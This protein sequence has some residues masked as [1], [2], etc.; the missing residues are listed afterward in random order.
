MR[1][2]VVAYYG[3]AGR[4]DDGLQCVPLV[5]LFQCQ[6]MAEDV[7]L[8]FLGCAHGNTTLR[9]LETNQFGSTQSESLNVVVVGSIGSRQCS[10]VCC[11]LSSLQHAHLMSRWSLYRYPSTTDL[12]DP[13]RAPI[14]NASISNQVVPANPKQH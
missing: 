8:G 5:K 3:G 6:M 9:T 1:V 2:L 13:Y 7:C 14:V 12:R 10:P 11:I 4:P